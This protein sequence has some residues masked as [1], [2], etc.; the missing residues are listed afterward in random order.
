MTQCTMHDP[1]LGFASRHKPE[2]LT[3]YEH[4]MMTASWSGGQGG[5]AD[6]GPPRP[7]PRESRAEAPRGDAAARPF[8][9][10]DLLRQ[11]GAPR[12]VY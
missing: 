7:G 4:F 3:H 2:S 6:C 9:P 5:A 12:D 8:Q 11:L 10:G 1:L